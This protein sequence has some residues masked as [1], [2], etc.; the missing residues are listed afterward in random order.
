[1]NWNFTI[2]LKKNPIFLPPLVV[3]S[4]STIEN[5]LFQLNITTL[6]RVI[7]LVFLQKIRLERRAHPFGLQDSICHWA[8]KRVKPVRHKHTF[9]PFHTPFRRSC[10]LFPITRFNNVYR[11]GTHHRENAQKFVF[12]HHSF[13]KWFQWKQSS[14]SGRFSPELVAISA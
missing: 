5:L 12:L 8:G 6:F 2:I 13:K 9:H 1:M 3:N 14:L 4:F 11:N 10:P 7:C